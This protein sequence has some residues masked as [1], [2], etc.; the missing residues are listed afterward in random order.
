MFATKQRGSS[1]VVKVVAPA[2]RDVRRGC[3]HPPPLPRQ[4]DGMV[5]WG[6]LVRF[7]EGLPD[8]EDT[9]AP[10]R[11]VARMRAVRPERSP[12]VERAGDPAGHVRRQMAEHRRV[13]QPDLHLVLVGPLSGSRT[14]PSRCP[15]RGRTGSPSRPLSP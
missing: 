1:T 3:R 14:S 2:V 6:R 12:S 9:Q 10:R 7:G 11:P 13:A 8:D 4:A 15:R 5:V